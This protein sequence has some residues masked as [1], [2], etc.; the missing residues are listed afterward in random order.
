MVTGAACGNRN[1]L[2]LR[3][4]QRAEH[5]GRC[6]HE[7]L[8]ALAAAFDLDVEH[9]T[10]IIQ[11]QGEKNKM[12]EFKPNI[13]QKLLRYAPILPVPITVTGATLFAVHTLITPDDSLIST[14]VKLFIF[15]LVSSTALL[16]WF[17]L[18]NRQS[19]EHG[20][21]LLFI[22][23]ILLLAAGAAGSVWAVHLG[24]VT[25][26]FEYY[27]ILLNLALLAQGGLTLLTLWTQQSWP[28]AAG[29]RN[30]SQPS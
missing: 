29:L 27:G 17:H 3:T 8:L 4:V 18:R 11:A 23:A 16:T 6:A 20:T 24:V 1:A 25:G 22:S 7:T 9:F 2:S 21:T 26:D 10:E 14:T 12:K 13:G 5:D 30:S 28:S 15:F 19:G